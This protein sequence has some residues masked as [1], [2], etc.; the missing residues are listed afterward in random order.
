ML[1]AAA[2]SHKG[3]RI[4]KREELQDKLKEALSL[5]DDLV[6]IEILVDT[7]AIVFPMQKKGG[8][9]SDMILCTGDVK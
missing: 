8:A 7:D 1:L 4:K 6:I 2:Y 9:M 3:V 5:K